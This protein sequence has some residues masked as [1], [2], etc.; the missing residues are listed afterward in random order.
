MNLKNLVIAK[1]D[2]M[3]E[4]SA[5]IKQ[6]STLK[7]QIESIDHEIM[8]AMEDVGIDQARVGDTTVFVQHQFVPSV[9]NWDDFYDYIYS[10][11]SFHLLERRPATKAWR[12]L[13]EG[14]EL[15]PGTESFEKIT[16]GKRTSH[17]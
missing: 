2:L 17:G 3:N 6:V 11:R 5:L 12:E 15:V 1:L 8:N 9:D 7:E 4:K 13:L 14:G 10:T 16:L